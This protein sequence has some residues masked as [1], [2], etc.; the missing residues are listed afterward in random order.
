M[1]DMPVVIFVDDEERILRSLRMLFRGQAE[2]LCTTR[3]QEAVEWTRSR[4]VHVVVSDQR[5]P[6]MTGVALLREVARH[7]PRTMRILLTG[8]AD[9]DAVAASVNEGEIFRFVEKPWD[10]AKLVDSVMRAAT[11]AREEL[12]LAH[13]QAHSATAPIA[14]SAPRLARALVLDPSQKVSRLVRDIVPESIEATAAQTIEAALGELVA[15][16]YA[17]IVAVLSSDAGDT[18]E[19]IK[20]LKKLRPAT[21]VIAISPLKDSRLTISLINEGQI[22]RFLLAPPG[23]ELL[24]RCLVSAFERHLQLRSTPRLAMRHEVEESRTAQASISGRL[25]DYW[26]R[27]R[28]GV[29]RQ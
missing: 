14:I 15:R 16:D 5:M 28:E 17:V 12:A 22:F 20:Q 9:M 19:A 23:R 8:Y 1:N 3:G 13:A 6:G 25:L 24:R 27:L 10:G 2:I 18:V 7:S 29:A 21:L 4:T 11:I 26:R